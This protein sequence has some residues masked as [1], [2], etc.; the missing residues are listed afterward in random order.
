M[1]GHRRGRSWGS[2]VIDPLARGGISMPISWTPRLTAGQADWLQSLILRVSYPLSLRIRY[3]K[4]IPSDMIPPTL[5][6]T[7]NR[8]DKILKRESEL[9]GCKSEQVYLQ[10]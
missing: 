6:L 10:Y 1:S 3:C 5:S 2:G 8:T 9:S 7:V 4:Q